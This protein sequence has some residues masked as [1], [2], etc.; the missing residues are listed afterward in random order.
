MARSAPA[1]ALAPGLWRI[2]V[3]TSDGINAFAAVDDHGAVTLV[4]AGMPW[5]WK[6]LVAG[7]RHLGSDPS[8]VVRI[9]VTHAHADHVGNVAKVRSLSGAGVDAHVDDERYLT[10]G[11]SP[12]IGPHIRRFRG[13]LQRWGRYPA[14]EVGSTFTDGALIDAGG[15]LRAHHTPGH[16]P[17]HTSFVHEPTGVLITGDVVHF[18]RSRIR[19][20]IKAYCNDVALNEQSAQTLGDL[21]GEVIAFTHGPHLSSDGRRSMHAFLASRPR[22]GAA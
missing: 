5:A 7:L 1:V 4:D 8:E 16:T 15:G 3:A 6:R 17:G 10:A 22:L 20:G 21:A 12:P 2:P 19:I 14:I 13:V 11:E 9:V 18:W